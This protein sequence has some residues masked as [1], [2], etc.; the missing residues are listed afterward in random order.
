MPTKKIERKQNEATYAEQ[1]KPCYHPDHRPPPY[2]VYP[3]GEYEH[4]CPACGKRIRF[5]VYPEGS[6]L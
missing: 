1:K 4:V 5:T 3:P 6:Y 2:M